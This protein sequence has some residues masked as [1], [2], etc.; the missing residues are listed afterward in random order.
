[1]KKTKKLTKAEFLKRRTLINK[2]EKKFKEIEGIL[3][4]IGLGEV[5]VFVS[6]SMREDGDK[7]ESISILLGSGKNVIHSLQN[8]FNQNESFKNLAEAAVDS[9]GE[10][11][12]MDGFSEFLMGKIVDDF[13]Q[14]IKDVN[15]E[16]DTAQKN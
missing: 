12:S 10:N 11:F 9:Y 4:K 15:K 5:G 7:F 16:K 6:A 8:S 2:V 3:A 1:M 13:K 14:H